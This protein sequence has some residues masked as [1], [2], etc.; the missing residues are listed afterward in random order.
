LPPQ[1]TSS[2][3]ISPWSS[4]ASPRK[5]EENKDENEKTNE[6]G[7]QELAPNGTLGILVVAPSD[8]CL[9]TAPRLATTQALRSRRVYH[10][11]LIQH[12]FTLLFG[13]ILL[14]AL[15]P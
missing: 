8:E 5:L 1:H 3:K 7:F 6:L 4:Q 15:E 2:L 14:P 9:T 13:W 10:L 12:T 11:L